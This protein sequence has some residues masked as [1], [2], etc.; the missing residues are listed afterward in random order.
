MPNNSYIKNVVKKNIQS[1]LKTRDYTLLKIKILKPALI[2]FPKEKGDFSDDVEPM[3]FDT[4]Y[5]RKLYCYLY[6]LDENNDEKRCTIRVSCDF[7]SAP[8]MF[9]FAP[10]IINTIYYAS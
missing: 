8:T 3:F 10:A 9:E 7:F 6:Y 2:I 1:H 5:N 4:T